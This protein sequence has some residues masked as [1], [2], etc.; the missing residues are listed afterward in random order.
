MADATTGSAV[1]TAPY[2]LEYVYKRSTGPTLG[3]FFTGLRDGRI[4]GIKGDGGGVLVPPAESD[5]VT[6][7]DLTELVEASQEGT[8]VTWTWIPVPRKA[9][10][11]QN[12]FAWGLI[13]LDGTQLPLLHAIDAGSEAR[14]KTGLRVKARWRPERIGSILDIA[15]FEPVDP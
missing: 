7:A 10:P 13:R 3:A 8:V 11:L 1:L 15:C 9:H 14:L 6:G 12:P 5:P 2:V 4:V